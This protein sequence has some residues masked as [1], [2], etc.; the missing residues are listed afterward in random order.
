[1][2]KKHA[3]ILYYYTQCKRTPDVLDR[4]TPST[5]DERVDEVLSQIIVEH[6]A[7]GG[8]PI[9]STER[10]NLC[11]PEF[12][13]TAKIDGMLTLGPVF[14]ALNECNL[15][16]TLAT[17]TR[18]R[19]IVGSNP[20]LLP[21]Y[22]HTSPWIIPYIDWWIPIAPDVAIRSDTYNRLTLPYRQNEYLRLDDG[23][24]VRDINTYMFKQSAVVAGDSQ[25]L[26]E[27]VVR[28]MTIA[29]N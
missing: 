4:P 10:E 9:T 17:N 11:R 5:S 27:S 25:E 1:M 29:S 6:Q 15:E 3:F 23:Q 28:D 19:F 14:H 24:L 8:K 12:I 26:I 16:I 22:H 2:T 21:R 20:V 7:A 18:G 13:R